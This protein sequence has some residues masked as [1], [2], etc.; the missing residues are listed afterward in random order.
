MEIDL[1]IYSFIF[2]DESKFFLLLKDIDEIKLTVSIFFL[3]FLI[4]LYII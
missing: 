3:F 4:S 1:I 2:I